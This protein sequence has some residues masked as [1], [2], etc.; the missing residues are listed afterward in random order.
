[1]N[2]ASKALQKHIQGDRKIQAYSK[3]IEKYH[4]INPKVM[5]CAEFNKQ[6]RIKA[7]DGL[8][9]IIHKEE[10]LFAAENAPVLGFGE[11]SIMM[12]GRVDEKAKAN[13]MEENL[14]EELKEQP[15]SLALA[16]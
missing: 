6:Y 11:L 7:F 13:A 2:T 3:T 12:A 4:R 14:V 16:E 5:R 9:E 1:M 8:K 15:D 10:I